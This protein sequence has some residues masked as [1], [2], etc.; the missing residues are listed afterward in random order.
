MWSA[1]A[2]HATRGNDVAI[3]SSGRII[4]VG[5]TNNTFAVAR[6][7]P[8][9]KLDRSFGRAGKVTVEFGRGCSAS[10]SAVAIDGSDRIVLAGSSKCLGHR[11]KFALSRLRKDGR[12][13]RGFGSNGRVTTGFPVSAHASAA[14]IDS[15]GRMV[16]AGWTCCGAGADDFALARYR[17]DGTLDPSFGSGGKV[18]TAFTTAFARRSIANAVALDSGG[19]IAAGTTCLCQKSGLLERL[20]IA[21]YTDAGLLDQTFGDGGTVTSGPDGE[22]VD[23][24]GVAVDPSRAIVVAGGSRGAQ[25][26]GASDFALARY[27]ST[28]ALDPTFGSGGEVSTDFGFPNDVASDLAIEPGGRIVAVGGSDNVFAL[29]RYNADGSLDSTFGSGGRVTTAFG[30]TS[31][32][33]ATA[34]ALDVTGDI[35]VGGTTGDAFALARYRQD[36]SLDPAFGSAGEATTTFPPSTWITHARIQHHRATFRFAAS[37]PDSGFQC[38]L[39]SATHPKPRFRQHCRH[40]MKTYLH[41]SAGRYT[42][43]VRAIFPSGPDPTPAKWRFRIR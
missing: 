10:A 21:R 33:H 11:S 3:D 23:P 40:R 29:A 17:Q 15:S 12:L 25:Y 5:G 8:S 31:V 42:F 41:L 16:P 35:I 19:I 22:G 1:A 30:P 36:G 38:A 20:A 28:G 26:G 32:S 43:E 2:A 14:A 34:V 6:Y 27:T 18:M 24:F 37:V 7:K 39:V 4:V 13:D 9:G